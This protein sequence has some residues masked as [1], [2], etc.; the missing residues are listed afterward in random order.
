MATARFL[1]FH[2]LTPEGLHHVGEASPGSADRNRT[3]SAKA[4]LDI[5][6][7]VPSYEQQVWFGQL[8]DKVEEIRC[9][10]VLTTAE[11]EALLSAVLNR[12]FEG[13]L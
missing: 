2:L 1:C 6:V 8:Y 10:Q 9:L 3:T 11:R 7:P 13:C 4:L 5:P 12:A